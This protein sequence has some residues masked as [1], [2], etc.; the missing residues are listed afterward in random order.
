[1]QLVRAHSLQVDESMLTGE[2]VP[3]HK[4]KGDKLFMGTILTAG[5]GEG[6]VSVTGMQTEMGK[7]ANLLKETQEEQTP[8]QKKLAGLGVFVAVACLVVCAAVS[9]IGYLSGQGL[10]DML[11]TGISLAVAAIPE[12][13]PA[14]VTIVLA[15]SVNRMLA[16]GAVIRRLHAVETLGCAGV[17]CTDKTGTVTQNKMAVQTIISAGESYTL[18]G[19]GYETGGALFHNGRVLAPPAGSPLHSALLCACVCSTASVRKEAGQYIVNGDPTEA[20]LLIAADKA[21]VTG[22]GWRVLHEN[23]FNSTRK[24]MSVLAEKNGQKQ[25]FCKGG[26]DIILAKCSTYATKDGTRPLTAEMRAK[27]TAQWEDMAGDAL[28]V[29]ALAVGDGK[30]E[31]GLCFLGIAGLQDPP[32]PEVADAVRACK[33]A[34]IRP[35]LITGDHK[36]T[37]LA[38]AKQVGIASGH[39]DVLT[40]PELEQMSERELARCCLKT[41]VYARVSPEHKL[42][43]V[44]AYKTAGQITVMTGDGVNDAPALKEANIGVAM[45]ITGTDVAKE[46]ADMVVLDDNFATIVLAVEEGRVIYQN[47]RRFIRYLLTSNLGEVSSMLLCML[48]GLPPPLLPIQILLMNLLTDGLPAIALGMEPPGA[49]IM[50]RPPRPKKEGLFAGGLGAVIAWRGFLLGLSMTVGFAFLI[51][52]GVPI[53]Q[54]RTAALLI[55]VLAQIAHLL[56]CRGS[57]PLRS[58]PYLVVACVVS[59]AASF[60]CVYCPPFMA[61][62]RAQALDVH[63]LLLVAGAVCIGP[64][65][66]RILRVV[67]KWVTHLR[68][69]VVQ[70]TSY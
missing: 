38:V 23:P 3:V 37:A 8:L 18:T 52:A 43:I 68:G 42:R 7:I 14:I 28:R 21:K 1:M 54:A 26:A 61:V 67:R 36:A 40:G 19:A 39:S 58:N 20:A 22:A 51:N 56:E 53:E 35:V 66:A 62:A 48:A 41:S 25:L 17:I 44:H 45:G 64:L 6:V 59:V 10:M 2:S 9:A 33:R 47:I 30:V 46:A 12:G 63:A 31:S 32:R 65:L 24:M 27:I 29:L 16:K 49:D 5:R 50:Q 11:L 70:P 15:L 57:A 4:E 60:L 13:L 69:G 55:M 34:G